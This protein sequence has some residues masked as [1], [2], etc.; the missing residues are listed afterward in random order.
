MVYD[1]PEANP[2]SD[3]MQSWI[4]HVEH[5]AKVVESLPTNVN[6]GYAYQADAATTIHATD[7]P[8]IVTDPPY[9]NSIDYADLSDYLYVWLRHALR[10]IYPDLFA[11]IMTPKDE[12]MTAI[13]SR[14][15]N[16]TE[17]FEGLLKQDLAT[18]KATLQP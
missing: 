6:R 9:Y 4:A 3:R 7:G 8:V 11:G 5:V 10:D 12:E 14:F 2:F 1:Y 18:H 16:H 17:R 15:E 13:P